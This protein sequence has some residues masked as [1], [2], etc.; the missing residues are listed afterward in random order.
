MAAEGNKRVILTALSVALESLLK[1]IEASEASG[2]INPS[3]LEVVATIK[4][5]CNEGIAGVERF[6][7]TED[8]EHLT[9]ALGAMEAAKA[10][11]ERI[12]S[13]P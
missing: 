4:A 3:H 6:A 7:E 2:D 11:I 8:I 10:A 12:N 13:A 1:E 5:A 9:T